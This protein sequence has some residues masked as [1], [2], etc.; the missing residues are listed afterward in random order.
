MCKTVK[1]DTG[2][3]PYALFPHL[4][5]VQA[6]TGPHGKLQVK[7]QTSPSLSAMKKTR[8]QFTKMRR[9]HGKRRKGPRQ[10]FPHGPLDF[11]RREQAVFTDPGQN[12]IY[13]RLSPFSKTLL[14]QVLAFSSL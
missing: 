14:S 12:P 3:V 5:Q 11:F 1:H 10:R 8:G 4:L 2:P 6:K 7:F 9:V 13:L